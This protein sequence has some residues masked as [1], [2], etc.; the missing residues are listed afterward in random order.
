M[1]RKSEAG[2]ERLTWLSVHSCMRKNSGRSLVMN[3]KT[4]LVRTS[5]TVPQIQV[6]TGEAKIW[7]AA[8]RGVAG[9]K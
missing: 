5:P 2:S 8:R 3:G 1:R 7:S 4:E 9:K 6:K